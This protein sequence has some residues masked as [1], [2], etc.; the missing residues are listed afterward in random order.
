MTSFSSPTTS[1]PS[2]ST[3]ASTKSASGSGLKAQWPPAIT[4]AS[5]PVPVRGA[6]REAGEVDQVDD[7]G[8][9]ELGGEVEGQH[10]EGGGREVLLDTEERHAGGAHGGLHVDPGCI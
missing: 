10:V 8:V 2:P 1:S 9:D 6:Q 7:V 4:S 5:A 3:K